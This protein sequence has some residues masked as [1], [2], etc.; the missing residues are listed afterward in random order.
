MEEQRQRAKAAAVSVDLTLQE[1][2]DQVAAAAEATAF[3]GYDQL[4]HPCCVLALV[5]NGQPAQRAAAGDSVQLVLDTTPFY[6]EGG[7]QVGDRGVLSGAGAAGDGVIVAI[8]AVTRNRSVFVHSGRVE[9]GC[10]ALGDLV[11]AQVDRAC[12]IGRAHV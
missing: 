3:R 10:L 9:R 12:Q 7:G 4:E 8:E 5:V 1:A 6:G 2:I 11:N